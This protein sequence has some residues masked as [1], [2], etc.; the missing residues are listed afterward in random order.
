MVEGIGATAGRCFKKVGLFDCRLAFLQE[1]GL[2]S[3]IVWSRSGGES[4]EWVTAH[5][6]GGARILRSVTRQ[7]LL[8]QHRCPA[9]TPTP[10]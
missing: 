2:C 4:A 3:L 6:S 9:P 5:I 1:L 10:W 7:L 8:L